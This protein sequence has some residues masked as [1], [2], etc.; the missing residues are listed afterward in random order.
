MPLSGKGRAQG[1]TIGSSGSGKGTGFAQL[2]VCGALSV[3]LFTVSCAMGESSPFVSVQWAVQSVVAPVR[4]LGDLLMTPFDGLANVFTNLTAD[5]ATLTELEAQVAELE[6]QVAE[7]EEAQQTAE[8]LQE[9]L[10]LQDAYSLQSTAA[11]II[12]DSTDSWTSTVT[13]DK[14]ST[15][16]IEVGMPVTSSSGVI[17]QVIE[18]SATTSVVRLLTDE[19][20]SIAAM[21][22]STRVQGMLEGS[23]SGTVELTLVRTSQTV[24]V[25]DI[26]V[27][28]GI[29][30]VFPKGLPLG[31]V[32]SVEDTGDLYLTITVELYAEVESAEEVLVITSLTEDQQADADDIAEADAQQ[33][34]DTVA[35]DEESDD[36]SDDS[37]E[38]A[39]SVGS[40]NETGE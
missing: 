23:A 40:D 18:V 9:L 13:I 3:V 32:T 36:S 28:S 22:Q 31:T 14:G 15:S 38:D 20:S 5:Q 30:G 25:G 39:D 37:S 33:E 16:G 7:L 19:G 29:G 34:D 17:G 2:V 35:S 6:A 27:T 26:I 21:V 12:S 24:E 1:P 8:R 4:S 11:R 10:D